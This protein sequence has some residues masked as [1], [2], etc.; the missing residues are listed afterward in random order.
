[1]K[2]IFILVIPLIGLISCRSDQS[3]TETV[4][5]PQPSGEKA[6]IQLIE[7]EDLLLD[8]SSHLEN[9]GVWM[10]VSLDQANGGQTPEAPPGLKRLR[11][12][13]PTKIIL[14]ER[15]APLTTQ[16]WAISGST[17]DLDRT[18]HPWLDLCHQFENPH[19]GKFGVLAATLPE[20]N[21]F[22]MKTVYSVKMTRQGMPYGLSATQTLIWIKNPASQWALDEW[23][24]HDLTLTCAERPL[25]RDTLAE[26]LSDPDALEAAI[27]S[28]HDRYLSDFVQNA[29]PPSFFPDPIEHFPFDASYVFPSVSVVDFDG[30]S[31]ED[32]FLSSRWDPTQLL[33]NKGDGTFEDVTHRSGLQNYVGVNCSIFADFDNDGDQD[34]L[35]G[36]S[37]TGA[38]FYLNE[39]G[40]FRHI[41]DSAFSNVKMISGMSVSDINRDGLLDLYLSTNCPDALPEN[42]DKWHETFLQEG[43]YEFFDKNAKDTNKWLNKPGPPN[44]IFMN[45]G[46]GE[47]EQASPEGPWSQWRMSYQA[48][49]G[50][51]DN[52][53]DDDLYICNDF[54]PDAFLRNDTSAGAS[55]PIF[56]DITQEALGDTHLGFGMGIDW[57][58]YDR[59]GDLDLYVSNMYSK[60]GKRILGQLGD[61]VGKGVKVAAAGNFLYQNDGS[62]FMQ[63]AGPGESQKNVHRTGWSYGGQFADFDNNGELDLYVP[64]GH[65]TAP[66]RIST[67]V[68]L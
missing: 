64:C 25:F 32:L 63:V 1:M 26:A 4:D 39:N 2:G 42:M 23:I 46:D 13:E 67:Q 35:I 8:F 41:R 52:D 30:D 3:K 65:Y 15:N 31:H 56:A 20:S 37:W 45:R 12:L 9:M 50:D 51:F 58:D 44:Y 48:A 6:I 53:G 36:F 19:E 28:D 18:Q 59:D 68:D 33:R 10:Q 27:S 29:N 57:G 38:K 34:A 60:A 22:E 5:F 61:R 62:R 7:A 43:E 55:N 40:R 21:R 66:K 24:Q 47:F 17:L 11:G 49:W 16:S 54:A 14:P